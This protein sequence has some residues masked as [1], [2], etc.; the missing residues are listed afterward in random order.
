MGLP[1]AGAAGLDN[2][3]RRFSDN[4]LKVELSGPE[5]PHLGEALPVAN[6]H[7]LQ[8]RRQLTRHRLLRI[9]N[10]THPIDPSPPIDL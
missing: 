1:R 5:H 2:L 6:R 3:E 9:D 4:V 10:Q 7:N 8:M